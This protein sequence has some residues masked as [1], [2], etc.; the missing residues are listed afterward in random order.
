MARSGFVPLDTSMA[1]IVPASNRV[2]FR[3]EALSVGCWQS[4]TVVTPPVTPLEGH[5]YIVPVG[6]SVAWGAPDLSIRHYYAGSWHTY[7]PLPAANPNFHGGSMWIGYIVDEAF[8]RI[9]W[10]G[11]AW[12]NL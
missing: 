6:A 3:L 4:R 5:V 1:D 12:V 9:R 10:D 8:Q 11:T 7:T 2:S